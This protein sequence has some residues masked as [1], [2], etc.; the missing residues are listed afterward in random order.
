MNKTILGLLLAVCVLGMTLI[1]LKERLHTAPPPVNTENPQ[2]A[3][4]VHPQTQAPLPPIGAS[5]GPAGTSPVDRDIPQPAPAPERP[6]A[7]ALTLPPEGGEK[8]ENTPAAEKTPPEP[9]RQA[10]ATGQ[11]AP[12]APVAETPEKPA[13]APAQQKIDRFVVFARDTGATLRLVGNGPISYTNT[14]LQNPERLVIDLNGQWQI[15]AP[16]VPKN[17]LVTNVRIGKSGGKTRVVIDLA[18]KPARTRHV[19]SKDHRMLDIRVDT[20]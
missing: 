2:S 17:P 1:M 19:L 7:Q 20:K 8:R 15:K 5:L 12:N 6:P 18:G 11:P 3:A 16:G 4:P 10:T 13:K 9:A 14:S